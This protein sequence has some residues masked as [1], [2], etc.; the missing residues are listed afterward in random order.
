MKNYLLLALAV[1]TVDMVLMTASTQALEPEWTYNQKEFASVPM[2]YRPWCYYWCLKGNFTE[3]KFTEDLEAMKKAG[4]S[5]L[6][7]FDSRGY[8][9]DPELHIPVPMDIKYEF[10]S[11][12]WQKKVTHMIKE[13]ERLGMKVSLN[14]SNTGGHLRGPWDFRNEGPREIVWTEGNVNGPKKY[15]V[16][17]VTPKSASHQNES[18]PYYIDVALLAVKLKSGA[19][20]GREVVQL[21]ETWGSALERADGSVVIDQVIDISDKVKNGKLVWDVPKGAWKII[22]FGSQVIGDYGSVD[23]LNKK[24]ITK[25]FDKIGTKMLDNAGTSAGKTLASFY[26]V[27]WEGSNPNWTEG[28][29]EF[30][31]QTRGY[32]IKKYLPALRGLIVG[33]A[34]E[35]KRFYIDF[36]RTISDCFCVNC[37]QQIGKLSHQRGV[38]WHS[39]DG[40]PWQRNAPMFRESDML[41]F[42]GQNDFP[43]GEFWVQE[44]KNRLTRS[45]MK[46]ASNAAHIYGQKYSSVEAFTHMT[47]HWTIYPDILKVAADS[48][49]IDGANMFI[50]H[51]FTNSPKNFGKPGIEY[52]AGT[53]VNTNVTWF[54]KVSPFTRYIGRCQ[55]LLR[56]GLF[57]A[58][59]CVYASDKNYTGWGRG[60]KWNPKSDLFAPKGT[61]YDLLDTNVL[62]NRL[63]YENGR[64]VLPDGM[65]YRYFVLDPMETEL[66]AAALEKIISLVKQGATLILGKT[67][68]VTERGLKNYPVGDQKVVQLAAELWGTGSE[69]VRALG[70]GKIYFG[71]TIEQVMTLEKQAVDFDGPFEYHHRSLKGSDI[72]FVSGNGGSADC[73]FRVS[74]MK[75]ELWDPMNGTVRPA[76][77]YQFME[78]GRTRVSLTLPKD[79]SV[80]VV[81]REK[82]DSKYIASVEGPKGA[83][84]ILNRKGNQLDAVIWTSGSWKIKKNDGTEMAISAKCPD[85]VELTGSWS[86][87]FDP[88]WGGPKQIVFDKLQYW[89]DRPEKGIKYY[90]GTAFYQK[91]FTLT[92]DQVKNELLLSLGKVEVI[93]RVKINGK[94]V[95]IVWTDPWTIDISRFV[96]VGRNELEV[97]VT[98]CWANRLIGDAGLPQKDRFTKT[99][100]HLYKLKVDGK[101]VPKRVFQGF[102]DESPLR[103]SGLI[104]PVKILSGVH[105]TVSLD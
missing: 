1:L 40:G 65:S 66:P 89:N 78:D 73:V 13:A 8:H 48:N 42:W 105:Q 81:F 100:I 46:F 33:S 51:T 56:K 19:V 88:Q 29:D 11:S 79:G 103:N 62:V 87:A 96:K 28:F 61:A 70:K 20:P 39:E 36:Y 31:K 6:L 95:G 45:N 102:S 41:T 9:E 104:G 24:I 71:Q 38:L 50:W 26:N 84:E 14:L 64:L 63:K 92:E 35:T 60:E 80:F 83:V 22:R 93:A 98:N 59:F 99:N 82:A 57:G 27:S 3:E 16:S 97:E 91:S 86:V 21:N 55:Y 7:F 25:Y 23:I 90:S 37:Y 68:P 85:P 18:A 49:L 67:Q 15:S 2:E 43:Q 34:E 54:D 52:F 77:S 76:E 17:M 47:W 44:K 4:F 58:D 75:P 5:G 10:M 69:K 94:E 53:H 30:F 72:Y 32:D 74:G 101:K 12:E